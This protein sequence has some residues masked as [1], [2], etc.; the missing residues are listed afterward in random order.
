MSTDTNQLTPT[1]SRA[2]RLC[3]QISILIANQPHAV[4]PG[5]VYAEWIGKL[6]AAIRRGYEPTDSEQRELLSV[7]GSLHRWRE[8]DTDYE[9]IL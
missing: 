3:E 9:R 6:S 5:N 8:L 1:Q 7:Q 4:D 2:L